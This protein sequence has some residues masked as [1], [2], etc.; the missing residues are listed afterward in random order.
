MGV[1]EMEKQWSVWNSGF[2]IIVD[3]D[4][5]NLFVVTIVVNF[6]AICLMK[7]SICLPVVHLSVLSAF[8]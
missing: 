6:V 5:I 2:S 1:R 8:K 4:I 7:V 3:R